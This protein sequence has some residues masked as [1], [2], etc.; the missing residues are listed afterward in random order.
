MKLDEHAHEPLWRQLLNQ[1]DDLLSAGTLRQGMN[2]PAEREMADALGVS[3]ITVKRCY[4]ELRQRGMLAGR[5]RGGSVLQAAASHAT[6]ARGRL[7]HFAEE[8]RELGMT[9]TTRLARRAV[10]GDRRIASLFGRPSGAQFLHVLC[11]REGD[12]LPIARELAWYDLTAAPALADWDGQ[13]CAHTFLRQQGGLNLTHAE[14]TVEAVQSSH[15]EMQL[16]NFEAPQP[17]LLFKRRTYAAADTLVEYVEG[18]FRSDA[19]A[20]RQQL[21]L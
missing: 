6:S 8:M 4:D 3:R 19:Y 7:S 16:F 1:I 10:V 14:Q 21:G 17:C 18:T 13:S 20:Y 5:G 15:D 9:A 2:L 12:G 11:V